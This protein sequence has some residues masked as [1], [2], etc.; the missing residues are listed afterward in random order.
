MKEFQRLFYAF[1][2]VSVLPNFAFCG[3]T[4][5]FYSGCS[6]SKGCQGF[7]DN[8][9]EGKNCTVAVSYQGFS[10]DKYKFEIIGKSSGSEVQYIAAG[11]STSGFMSDSSV[12]TCFIAD[13]SPHVEMYWNGGYNSLPLADPQLGLSDS[14]VQVEDGQMYCSFVRDS[15]TQFETSGSK[16][17]NVTFDLNLNEFT[18]IF[19]TGKLSAGKLTEHDDRGKTKTKFLLADFNPF[20]VAEYNGCSVEKG[21]VGFPIGCLEFKNCSIFASYS[22]VTETQYRFELYGKVDNDASSYIAVG[23]SSSSSMTE[24]SVIACSKF[25]EKTS[26]E[27]Y[28]NEGYESL[29]LKEASLGLSNSS[30]EY[31][32]GYLHCSVISDALFKFS[33]PFDPP[34]EAEFDLNNVPYHVLLVRGPLNDQGL[35][36]KHTE[37]IKTSEKI[38][39]FE[40]GKSHP[41]YSG[42]SSDKGC[43]GFPSGCVEYKNCSILTTYSGISFEEYKFE[44]YGKVDNDNSSYVAV[45]LSSTSSMPSSSVVACSK[46]NNQ[47]RIEMYWNEGYDSKPLSDTSLG[48]TDPVVRFMNGY[49]YCSVTRKALTTISTPTDPSVKIDFDL[50]STPYHLLI[51]RGP[52]D[53]QGLLIKHTEKFKTLETIELFEF[54]KSHPVY[55][56]CSSDKGCFGF[57]SGCA[58]HKNCTILTTYSGISAEEYKFEIYGKVDNETSSYVAVGLSLSANMTETSVVACSKFKNES[59]VEMYWNERYDSK[60]LADT[61]LGLSNKTVD[62]SAGYLYCSVERNAVT[63]FATPFIPE[64]AAEFDLNTIAYHILLARGPLNDQGLLSKHTEKFKSSEQIKLSD[65]NSFLD[66]GDDVY[67][68]CEVSK[69]CFGIGPSNCEKEKNCQL[70]STYVTKSNGDVTFQISGETGET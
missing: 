68:G 20:F 11:L 66:G 30:V 6:T 25:N 53:D 2:C 48:L 49:I 51:A 10:G 17:K 9:I 45:G 13:K 22:G 40:F 38:D 18:L 50:N 52:L 63:K 70:I 16:P 47:N 35:L 34:K 31:S 5:T 3:V 65:F 21:C 58:E 60:P 28:W 67:E 62:Y 42:C 29:P 44:I 12:M 26:I 61:S 41:V 64:K 43:F 59:R 54:G 4:E 56:G 36:K 14:S 46:F 1:L 23:L 7:P 15:L 32:N 24:T 19:A 57:P 69:G 8:C 27:R 37:K 39:I 55:S 33:T